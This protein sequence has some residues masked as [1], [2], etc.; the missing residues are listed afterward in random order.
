MLAF[1]WAHRVNSVSC[2]DWPTV[3]LPV[4]EF[5]EALELAQQLS[6]LPLGGVGI[7]P[8]RMRLRHREGGAFDL[9]QPAGL[10]PP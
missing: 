3:Q 4:P 7:A 6:P 10:T 5:M 8:Q 1:E 9:K 2:L